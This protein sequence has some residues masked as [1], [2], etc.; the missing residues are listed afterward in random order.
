MNR[1]GYTI[2]E[3]LFPALIVLVFGGGA[4]FGTFYVYGT[5]FEEDVVITNTYTRTK[6]EEGSVS[7][8]YM[9]TT[10]DNRNFE[11]KDSLLRWHFTSTD[12]WS[13]A[14][15]RQDETVRIYGYGWRVPF[16]SMFP[17]V[18]RIEDR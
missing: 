12:L 13:F 18:Y 14:N 4:L 6:G 16:L 15:S 1:Y 9:I 8:I 10:S 17:N 7:Q 2:I 11:V 3:L 5:A